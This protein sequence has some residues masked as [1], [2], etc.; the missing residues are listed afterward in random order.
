MNSLDPEFL[1][2][3]QMSDNM[4]SYVLAQKNLND[5]IGLNEQTFS[6]FDPLVEESYKA[7]LNARQN[8][9]D[10]EAAFNSVVYKFSSENPA[11]A[12]AIKTIKDKVGKIFGLAEISVGVPVLEQL[13][14][15]AYGLVKTA[16]SF[17]DFAVD[18]F[19]A[20]TRTFSTDSKFDKDLLRDL[21]TSETKNKI[22]DIIINNP[23][24]ASTSDLIEELVKVG[25]RTLVLKN[26]K[27][28]KIRDKDGNQVYYPTKQDAQAV[29]QFGK[30]PEKYERVKDVNFLQDGNRVYK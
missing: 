5:Q 3:Y 27:V 11:Y 17:K 4:K 20:L 28:D 25:D 6:K 12:A 2:S 26:G 10:T 15:T 22:K 21:G 14:E 23:N 29:E 19:G 8:G 18:H 16:G 1:K 30:N 9:D 24:D 13:Q 7:I